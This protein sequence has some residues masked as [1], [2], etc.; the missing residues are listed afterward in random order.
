MENG[1]NMGQ[2]MAPS[3]AVV[4]NSVAAEPEPVQEKKKVNVPAILFGITTLIFAGL[5]VYFGMEY[6][7]PKSGQ[8]G[9]AGNQ[10]GND[11]VVVET[12][13]MAEDYREVYDL[14]KGLVAD[15]GTGFD[16]IQASSG[17][18]YKPEGTNT[19]MPMRFG[20]SARISSDDNEATA[21]E[22]GTRLESKG[23]TSI[24]VIPHLGSA[25]PVIYGYLNSD[26]NIVCETYG[27]GMFVSQDVWRNYVI[28]ECAKVDWHFLTAE[29]KEFV[30]KLETAYFNKT[31]KY[32]ITLSG[33]PMNLTDLESKIKNSQ[34]SPY[35]TLQVAIGGGYALFYRVSPDAEWQYFTGG[36]GPLSCSDYDTEDLRKAFAG[37]AC[38][39]GQTESTVQP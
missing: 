35:Q 28:L 12:A 20:L 6:F 3:Q 9:D 1:D 11:A 34:I 36:Q 26:K 25:G 16:R 13:D 8:N 37:D 32:P 5:A 10:G 14:M 18:I 17:I 33:Y 29:E 23:F 27:D 4:N 31:G 39:D 2:G 38:F 30:G 7:K 21:L 24:G 15:L 19:Y 22:L